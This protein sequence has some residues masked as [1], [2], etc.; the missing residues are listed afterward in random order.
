MDGY[1]RRKD[2]KQ[3]RGLDLHSDF[4]HT[5]SDHGQTVCSGT[6]MSTAIPAGGMGWDVMSRSN[7]LQKFHT[8]PPM[9]GYEPTHKKFFMTT[10]ILLFPTIMIGERENREREREREREGGGGGDK[11]E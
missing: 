1:S 3:T 4:A 5:C 9:C 8:T 2:S 11:R 10:K 7:I 6:L